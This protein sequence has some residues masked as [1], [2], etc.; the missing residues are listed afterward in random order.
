MNEHAKQTTKLFE[1]KDANQ[2]CKQFSVDE[3]QVKEINKELFF[4]E[5]FPQTVGGYFVNY[6]HLQR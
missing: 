2:Q 5:F 4:K 6:S 3:S 1:A